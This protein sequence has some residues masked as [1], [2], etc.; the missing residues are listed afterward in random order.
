MNP[1]NALQSEIELVDVRGFEPLTPCR[2]TVQVYANCA[3]MSTT[4]TS[5]GYVL[6]NLSE[7]FLEVGG[8]SSLGPPG[9]LNPVN[10]C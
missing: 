8:A 6:S 1:V 3:S 4:E 2:A 5:N 7:T 10:V 9:A